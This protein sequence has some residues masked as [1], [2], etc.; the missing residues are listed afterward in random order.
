MNTRP[1]LRM[2]IAHIVLPFL[3]G[4]ML[5]VIGRP[6]SLLRIGVSLKIDNTNILIPLP[7]WVV[8]NLPDG[9]WLYSFLM[10][11]IFIWQGQNNREAFLWYSLLIVIALGSELLQK[12]SLTLGTFDL[13]DIL[14]YLIAITL[15]AF[16]YFQNNNTTL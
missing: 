3:M 8:Y 2:Y 14:A 1:I 13:L 6:L 10:L 4:C 11:L 9:L 12:Y 5:Y 16:N 15:C 7:K